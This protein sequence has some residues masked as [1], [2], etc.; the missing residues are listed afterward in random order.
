MSLAT[1]PQALRQLLLLLLLLL[2]LALSVDRVELSVAQVEGSTV[3]CT[4]CA[5]YQV[6]DTVTGTKRVGFHIS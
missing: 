6:S 4:S 5:L 3:R 1:P 2:L